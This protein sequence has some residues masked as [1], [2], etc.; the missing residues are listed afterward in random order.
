[1]VKKSIAQPCRYLKRHAPSSI[2]DDGAHHCASE[3]ADG[4]GTNQPDGERNLLAGDFFDL[5]ESSVE[6]FICCAASSERDNKFNYWHLVSPVVD[7]ETFPV[8]LHVNKTK[9]CLKR[10]YFFEF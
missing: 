4:T 3:V 8:H 10:L 2:S 7:W 1:M 9:F 5:V 6:N